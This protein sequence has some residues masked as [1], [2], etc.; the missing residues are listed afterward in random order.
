[1][2]S[3]TDVPMLIGVEVRERLGHR[4]QTTIG[5]VSVC[6]WVIEKKN[7]NERYVKTYKYTQLN[8]RMY[9]LRLNKY[10]II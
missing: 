4:G 3:E 5:F 7:K 9:P 8:D 1:M 2:A 10:N 6:E